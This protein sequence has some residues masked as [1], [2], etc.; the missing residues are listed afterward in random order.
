[1]NKYNV[2][3]RKTM[4]AY[5]EVDAVD[6]SVAK[7]VAGHEAENL[8]PGD[9][10]KVGKIRIGNPVKLNGVSNGES[11]Y[12]AELPDDYRKIATDGVTIKEGTVVED[13]GSYVKVA[14]A[15]GTI[16][17]IAHTF[18]A[19]TV[20]SLLTQ[21]EDYVNDLERAD[22]SK[23]MLERHKKLMAIR[24]TLKAEGDA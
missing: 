1:M 20:T 19:A 18:V 7:M 2:E 17:K 8:G 16:A 23:R 15:D 5:I 22:L 24:D 13:V 12:V 14:F 21:I 10:I 11:T 6:E 3:V 9:W 4:I